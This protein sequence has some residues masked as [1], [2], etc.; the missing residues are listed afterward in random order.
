MS[1]LHN[2]SIHHDC[3]NLLIKT[4]IGFRG[5]SKIIQHLNL[6]SHVPH[7]TSLINW[8]LRFGLGLLKQVQPISEPW[9]AIIDHSIDIGSKWCYVLKHACL[10]QK[11]AFS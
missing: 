5:L 10:N 3:V 6:F 8:V 9:I 11:K 7:F 2:E 1:H 4:R